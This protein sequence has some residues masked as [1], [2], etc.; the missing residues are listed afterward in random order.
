[1]SNPIVIACLVAVFSWW[2]FTGI[3]LLLVRYSD[4]SSFGLEDFM[5]YF[6]P[7]LVAGWIDQY[8]SQFVSVLAVYLS[9]LGAMLVWGWLEYVFLIGVITGPNNQIV[10]RMLQMLKVYQSMG[11]TSLSR[12]STPYSLGSIF[13]LCWS[14]ENM[15]GLWTFVILYFARICAKL[16]LFFGVPRINVEFVPATLSHLTSHF[17][18][19]ALNWFFPLS[20]TILTSH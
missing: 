17:K 13:Y 16:N 10:P 9:F 2:F 11:D 7:F 3:I 20:V 8:S 14:A 12:D 18:I 15:F 4:G 5:R 19:S 1:M 6:T